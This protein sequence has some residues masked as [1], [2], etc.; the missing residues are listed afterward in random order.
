MW[1]ADEI[2]FFK[3][4]SEKCFMRARN[5]K[6][7]KD[8]LQGEQGNVQAQLSHQVIMK[9]CR[10]VLLNVQAQAAWPPDYYNM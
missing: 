7:E 6:R 10:C 8:T 3:D 9:T 1:Q 2:N 5:A 4:E